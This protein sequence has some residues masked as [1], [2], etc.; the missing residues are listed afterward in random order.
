[1]SGSLDKALKKLQ[2]L[3][4]SKAYVVLW[5]IKR[6]LQGGVATYNVASVKIDKPL[7]R[8]LA[9]IAAR[10]IKLSNQVREYEFLAEDH[11]DDVALTVRLSETDLGGIAKQISN[12]SDNAR[13]E[14][15]EQLFDSWAYAIE[16]HV[17]DQR[18]LA[19]HKIPEGWK[20]KQ[21][22]V[23]LSAMF[24]NHMLLD[25]ENADIFRLDKKIDFF[26]YDGL[27]FILDKKKF[28][29]AMN[30]RAGMEK[31]RDA[32]LADLET[33]GVVDGV[34]SIRT[35]VGTRLS[36]LRRM[37]MINKNG[38][39]KKADFLARLKAVCGERKWPITFVGDKIV[40]TDENVEV[41]LKLLNNDRLASPVTEEV[42]DVSAK[43]KVEA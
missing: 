43:R 39:Y 8:K 29:L 14:S 36:F 18:V 16:L 7:Q 10:A 23:I 19:L 37:A 28:E 9:S 4:L 27:I 11:D 40:V 42:F 30:F 22:D 35:K 31:S 34:A 25:F 38:Y 41:V 6:Q 20:L 33:L 15:A 32:V 5:I 24:K 1:M 17:G 13:I 2:G 21:K 12:G 3:P 26:A